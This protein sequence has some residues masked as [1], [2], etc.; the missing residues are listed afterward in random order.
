VDHFET[1]VLVPDVAAEQGR[2]EAH[3]H[4]P[5]R[6]H[7]VRPAFP[8]RAHQ[9][10]RTRFEIAADFVDGRRADA[11]NACPCRRRPLIRR[12]AC[13]RGPRRNSVRRCRSPRRWCRRPFPGRAFGS[14]SSRLCFRR[15]GIVRAELA[16]RGL[17]VIR[18]RG[19][20][21]GDVDEAAPAAG[22]K[23]ETRGGVE[24]GALPRRRW[25]KG[26]TS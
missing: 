1:V 20:A 2:R 16:P 24:D 10:D 11:R 3:H 18:R 7:D 13:G 5:A 25:G 26:L 17:E 12:S 23:R 14:S 9:H 15:I 22:R 6:G 19:L 21:V 8:R 4:V